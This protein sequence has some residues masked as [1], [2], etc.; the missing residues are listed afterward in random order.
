[1]KS[2]VYYNKQFNLLD[3]FR[4]KFRSKTMNK[5]M[6]KLNNIN[7]NIIYDICAWCFTFGMFLGLAL[8][9]LKCF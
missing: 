8:L 2:V 6:S 9:M 4:E 7:I 1:M 3:K 5:L